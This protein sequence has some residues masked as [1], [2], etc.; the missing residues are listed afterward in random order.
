MT[1]TKYTFYVDDAM[2]PHKNMLASNLIVIPHDGLTL[3]TFADC[4]G[5]KSTCIDRKHYTISKT[6][7]SLAIRDGA[8]PV[9]KKELLSLYKGTK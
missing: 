9:S 1:D 2:I 8:I 3:A 5:L 6:K 7:R 4:I